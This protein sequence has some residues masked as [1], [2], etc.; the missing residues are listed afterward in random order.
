[1]DATGG[2]KLNC[3]IYH[4]PYFTSETGEMPILYVS[5]PRIEIVETK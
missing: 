4:I 5:M 2:G 1:V 3:G